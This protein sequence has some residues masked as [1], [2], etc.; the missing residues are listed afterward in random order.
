M[1]VTR[2]R[3]QD[4][5][6]PRGHVCPERTG[7]HAPAPADRSAA[8]RGPAG[9]PRPMPSAAN[10][11]VALSTKR[12]ENREVVLVV[13]AVG[14]RQAPV[15]GVA[16]GTHERSGRSRLRHHRHGDGHQTCKYC[17]LHHA[18]SPLSPDAT[19]S[20]ILPHFESN[21]ALTE[22]ARRTARPAHL[23]C[24]QRATPERLA[25]VWPEYSVK[26]SDFA[27]CTALQ[28]ESKQARKSNHKETFVGDPAGAPDDAA[29][30]AV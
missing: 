13:E 30:P 26:S 20:E 29:C 19:A 8:S 23:L 16:H 6:N 15:A 1:L 28:A 18:I 3:R 27:C 25:H 9:S 17:L 12:V 22:T 5:R 24:K 7:R 11:P 21:G 10:V 14:A 4:E 2:E